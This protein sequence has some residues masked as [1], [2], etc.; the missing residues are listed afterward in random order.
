MKINLQSIFMSSLISEKTCGCQIKETKFTSKSIS[1]NVAWRR[2]FKPSH[3]VPL[4]A[5]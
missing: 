4:K 5:K 2:L 1:I 3:Q